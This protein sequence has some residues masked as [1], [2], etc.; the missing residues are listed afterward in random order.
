MTFTPI[1]QIAQTQAAGNQNEA[2]GRH[3]GTG[4]VT[5]HQGSSEI[6][7]WLAG[8]SPAD[9][10][11]AA[12]LRASQHG[13]TLEVKSQCRFPMGPNGERLP[14]YFVAV[15][16]EVSGTQEQRDAALA[17]LRKFE[18]PATIRDIEIWLAELSVISASRNREGVESALMLTAYSSRLAQYPA[19]V[20]RA[21]VLGK[22]WKWWPTWEELERVC[23]AKAGPRRQMIAALAAPIPE[24]KPIR[25]EPTQAEKDHIAAL[26]AEKFPNVPQGWRDRAVE[27]A[28]Q[29]ECITEGVEP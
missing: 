27:E 18:T 19:D 20:A 12:V 21:A 11:K 29:G 6:G 15:G 23:E 3:G 8:K 25:R 2:G 5:L 16:C 10:D 26:V 14:S 24:P 28:T 9:M 22:T 17:D 1:G 4:A 7:K 13:V